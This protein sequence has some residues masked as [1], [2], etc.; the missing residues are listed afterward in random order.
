MLSNSQQTTLVAGVFSLGWVSEDEL[1]KTEKMCEDMI[2]IQ[3]LNYP[4]IR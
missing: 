3:S 1:E 4:K 2:A